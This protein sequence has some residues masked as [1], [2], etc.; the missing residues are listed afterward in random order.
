ML[1]GIETTS[2]RGTMI[3]RATLSLSSKTASTISSSSSSTI[4]CRADC[5]RRVRISSS[6]CVSSP[7]RAGGMPSRRVKALAVPLKTM[8]SGRST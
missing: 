3:S 4:P 7:S 2:G 1:A 6:V 8:V 5:R